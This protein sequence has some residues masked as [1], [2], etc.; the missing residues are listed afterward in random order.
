MADPG[1][2]PGTPLFLDQSE[3]QRAEK[4]V[5]ETTLPTYLRVWMPPPPPPP[6]VSRFGSGTE[7]D[8]VVM[9]SLRCVGTFLAALLV[10]PAFLVVIRDCMLPTLAMVVSQSEKDKSQR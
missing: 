8:S 2:G 1:K 4:N 9:M 7:I 10:T 6:L 5:L 3:A